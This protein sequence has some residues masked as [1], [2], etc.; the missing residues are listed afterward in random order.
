MIFVRVCT[1]VNKSKLGDLMLKTTDGATYGFNGGC[2]HAI[3]LRI[4]HRDYH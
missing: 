3:I 2:E 1:Y 4:N